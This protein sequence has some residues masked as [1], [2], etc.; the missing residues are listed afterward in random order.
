MEIKHI[1]LWKW[2]PFITSPPLVQG[3]GVPIKIVSIMMCA[4]GTS[5]VM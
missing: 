4:Q 3:F 2:T 1:L 5:T